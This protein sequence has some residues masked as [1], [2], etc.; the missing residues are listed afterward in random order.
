MDISGLYLNSTAMLQDLQIRGRLTGLVEG[1]SA[2]QLQSLVYI[3]TGQR[4]ARL[5]VEEDL[6]SRAIEHVLNHLAH[7]DREELVRIRQILEIQG[8]TI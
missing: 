3:A 1:A 4:W 5:E 6:G 8:V 7:A 2:D